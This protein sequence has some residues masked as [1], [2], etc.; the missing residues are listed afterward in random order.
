MQLTGS[1]RQKGQTAEHQ[2]HF[3]MTFNRRIYVKAAPAKTHPAD[4]NINISRE[5]TPDIS[6]F[7]GFQEC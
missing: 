3:F 1:F 2:Q 6:R 5:T 7:P 4:E